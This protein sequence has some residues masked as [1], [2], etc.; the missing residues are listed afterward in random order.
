MYILVESEKIL[1]AVICCKS[2]IVL[3]LLCIFV[4]TFPLYFLFGFIVLI[5]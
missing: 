5:Y 1:I 4:M 2:Y 3:V